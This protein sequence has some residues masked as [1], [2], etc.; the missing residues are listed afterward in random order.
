MI[1]QQLFI[2]GQL[3][4]IADNTEV[5]LVHESNILNGAASFT[6]NHSL[7]IKLPATVRNKAIF[8]HADLVQSM[9]GKAYQWHTAEYH[10]NGVPVITDGKCCILEATPEGFQVS[11]IWGMKG[12]V[13]AVLGG[14]GTLADIE[15]NAAIEFHATPQLTPYATAIQDVTEVFYAALDTVRHVNIMDTYHMKVT[16]AER[17]WDT[18]NTHGASSYLHPSVKMTWLLSKIEAKYGCVFDWGDAMDDI[19]TMIV[20]LVSKVPNDI[21]FN[22]GYTAHVSEPGTWGGISGSYVL[23]STTHGSSIIAAQSNP[24]EGSLVCQ[25][26]FNG[27]LRFSIYLY[28]DELISLGY[29]IFRSKYGYRLDVNVNGAVQSCVIIPE[30][31]TFMA[32]ERDTQGRIGFTITGSLPIKMEVGNQLSI[33]ITSV[34]N[35]IADIDRVGGIHVNGGELWINDIIG[36]LNELQPTQMYPVQGNLPEIKVADLIKFLCAVTGYFPVQASTASVLKMRAVEDVFDWDEAE[37][38]TER[39]LSP[40]GKAIAAE[41]RYTPSGWAKHNWWRWKEDDTVVGNYDG[42]ITIDDETIDESRDIMT[43]PFAATDG[44]N[45]PMYTT[46]YKYDSESQ[47]WSAEVKWHKV[48]PR[49]LHMQADGDGNASAYF[50]FDVSQ[51]VDKYYYDLV[52]TMQNPVIITETVRMSNVQFMALDEMKPVFLAQ[53]G[54][55]FALLSCELH[56]DGTAKVKLLRLKKM[57]EL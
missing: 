30:G 35:G 33:R 10:R 29:P 45:L 8:Y 34:Y 7:T 48:E 11:L 21:T 24:P 41:T 43:F 17:S 53:H 12:A 50:D 51:I 6:S 26:A 23:M 22:G 31:S 3:A 28:L 39:L 32:Q 14:E 54:A 13:D 49:V 2:D 16:F 27:L 57:E 18:N 46:E 19:G 25:T 9:A 5:T 20:S 4:D 1:H 36:T 56:Q 37:D 55:Y 42:G 15:T 52:A 47:V 38:W 40:T 44:N